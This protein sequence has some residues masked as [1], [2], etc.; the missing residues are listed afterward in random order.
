MRRGSWD[1]EVEAC[2]LSRCKA[3]KSPGGQAKEFG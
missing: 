2:K 3:M 1:M